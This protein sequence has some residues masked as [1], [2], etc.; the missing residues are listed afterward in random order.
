MTKKQITKVVGAI[1]ARIGNGVQVPIMSLGAVREA[2]EACL[3]EG[4]TEASAEH[5]MREA[6]EAVR[7]N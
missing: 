3:R 2:G 7:A 5:A 4:L 6:L 1:Y